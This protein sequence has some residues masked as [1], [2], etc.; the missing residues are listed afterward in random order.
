MQKEQDLVFSGIKENYFCTEK[1]EKINNS[2][3]EG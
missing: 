2:K 3:V 1:A